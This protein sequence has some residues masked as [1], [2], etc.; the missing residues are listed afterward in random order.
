MSTSLVR[1]KKMIYPTNKG[2]SRNSQGFQLPTLQHYKGVNHERGNILI[3]A[4]TQKVLML[5]DVVF[6]DWV[7]FRD[8][9]IA[10]AGAGGTQRLPRTI[11]TPAALMH[12]LM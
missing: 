11:G 9:A 12:I 1:T 6:P 2:D 4:P 5:V 7:P 3:Y 8:L 10:G